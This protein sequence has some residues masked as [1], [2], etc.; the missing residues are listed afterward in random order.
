MRLA[1]T[2]SIHC[3]YGGGDAT[4]ASLPVG[5]QYNPSQT[6]YNRKK[7][8]VGGPDKG[9][10]A[11]ASKNK[12]RKAKTLT[13]TAAGGQSEGSS[14]VSRSYR[15]VDGRGRVLHKFR[16]KEEAQEASAGNRYSRV[17]SQIPADETPEVRDMI[18][19]R[20]KDTS[21]HVHRRSEQWPNP[22]PSGPMVR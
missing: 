6:S 4:R 10:I 1:E 18:R 19:R 21:L 14:L 9:G 13:S 15:V 20:P 12:K 16:T 8:Q 17:V 7:Q 22:L 2:L 5:S 3:D 11:S